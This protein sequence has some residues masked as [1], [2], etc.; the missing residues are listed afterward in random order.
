MENNGKQLG[1]KISINGVY[2]KIITTPGCE[3][4]SD[5]MLLNIDLKYFEYLCKTL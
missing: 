1:A 3:A 2:I 5:N 4:C